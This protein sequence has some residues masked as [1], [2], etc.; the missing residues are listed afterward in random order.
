MGMVVEW[1]VPPSVIIS[2]LDD[3]ERRLLQALGMLADLF[4]AKMQGEAQSGAPWNDVT[5]AARQG[6][7]GQ[8]MKAATEVTIY[9]MHSV[10]YGPYLE[11]GTRYMAPRPII[12]PVLQ[13]NYPEVMAEV[14]GLLGV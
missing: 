3:Y 2:G 13:A 6:L 12:L 1:Q 4:A 14:R 11:L 8:A 10:H 7:R 5:G 9:L